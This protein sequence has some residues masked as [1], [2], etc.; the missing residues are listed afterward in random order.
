MPPNKMSLFASFVRDVVEP[1]ALTLL[2]WAWT[3]DPATAPPL[4]QLTAA[5]L[6]VL[7]DKCSS[8][9]VRVAPALADSDADSLWSSLRHSIDLVFDLFPN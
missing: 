2:E 7:I 1:L 5:I 8:L 9:D 4:F 3:F 6:R